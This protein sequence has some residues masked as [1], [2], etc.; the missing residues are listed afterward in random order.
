MTSKPTI[1]PEAGL[2]TAGC[3]VDLFE[4]TP[5]SED[6]LHPRFRMLRDRAEFAPAR[7]LLR[8]V[9]APAFRETQRHF[10]ERFQ[11]A[12]FDGALFELFLFALFSA[13]GH[14]VDL[15]HRDP[16]FLLTMRNESAAVDALTVG[17]P[18]TGVEPDAQAPQ[19]ASSKPQSHGVGGSLFRKLHRRQW[20]R[21]HVQGR[22]FVVAVQD[23]DHLELPQGAPP[24]AILGFLFGGPS[25]SREVRELFPDGFFGQ[26]EA[27][28]VSA[29]LFCNDATIAKFNRI[30]QESQGGDAAR[31]LRH[32]T[33]LAG[34]CG[35]STST[36]YVYE[37]GERGSDREQWNE[38]TVLIHNPYALH[39]LPTDW[40]GASAEIE[41]RDA[42]LCEHFARGFHPFS[43]I[44]EL[45]AANTPAWWIEQRA[46]LLAQELKLHPPA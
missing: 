10:V 15:R 40:L 23:F 37:V 24:S 5:Q 13:A 3:A 43:S 29:I 44:T 22:P 9:H 19:G 12:D 11:V 4:V 39:P 2:Q 41:L 38:G 7:S 32:G 42:R 33:C 35:P 17:S 8:Q 14:Q 46:R 28:H 21:P 20:R 34:T 31:M 30:G 36:G 27:E 45:L 1:R 16:A 18:T 6:H 25:Q 26:Q